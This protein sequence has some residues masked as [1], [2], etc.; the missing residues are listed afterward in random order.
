[1]HCWRR[2]L[3]VCVCATCMTEWLTGVARQQGSAARKIRH[4]PHQ[5]HASPAA[6]TRTACPVLRARR[7]RR[8]ARRS[9][10]PPS[11]LQ[12][13]WTACTSAPR[14]ASRCALACSR[15]LT[16][17][18]RVGPWPRA[19]RAEDRFASWAA[20][21][22]R[23]ERQAC[24]LRAGRPGVAQAAARSWPAAPPTALHADRRRRVGARGGRDARQLPRRRG[25][26][27]LGG[28]GGRHG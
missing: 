18:G 15:S 27:P 9:G 2:A 8:S 25:V 16:P 20:G 24:T 1:M 14:P 13:R 7:S 23:E 6:M 19:S 3:C 12:A 21:R 11:P 26:E 4:Q 17:Q 5:P 10:S 28:Q 22:W